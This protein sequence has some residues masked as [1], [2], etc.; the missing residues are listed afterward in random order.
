MSRTDQQWIA[1]YILV[2]LLFTYGT[3]AQRILNQKTKYLII[4]L[5]FTL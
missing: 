3:F 4:F 1:F 2:T 5:Y